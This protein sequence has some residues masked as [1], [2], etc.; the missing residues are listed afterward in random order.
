MSF[1]PSRD[2]FEM[3]EGEVKAAD[4]LFD[5]IEKKYL[6]DF[7]EDEFG[8]GWTFEKVRE[9]PRYKHW[10]PEIGGYDM[11]IYMLNMFNV[12]EK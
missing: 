4:N 11:M 3:S 7:A 1:I 12:R 9:D 6:D 5:E 2:V 8:K 10:W